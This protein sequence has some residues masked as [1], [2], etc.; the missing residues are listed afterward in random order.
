M[1]RPVPQEVA[2]LGIGEIYTIDAEFRSTD[3]AGYE[4]YGLPAAMAPDHLEPVC[5]SAKRWTTGETFSWWSLTG[6]SCPLPVNESALFIA[7]HAPAEWSYFLAKGWE[8]PANII[9]LYAEY[10]LTINGLHDGKGEQI[11]HGEHKDADGRTKYGLLSAC[12]HYG[13]EAR[14]G[15][16]K[17]SMVTRILQGSPFSVDDQDAI[18]RYNVKDVEDAELLFTRMLSSGD[19]RNIGQALMRG[20]A[21]RGFAVRDR[22]GLPMDVATATRLS[23]HWDSIRSSLAHDVEAT[24]H[25]DVFRFHA[26]GSAQF[27]RNKMIALVERLGM[28]DVWPRTDDH[29]YSFADPQRGGD[30][31]KPFKQMAMLNPYL[32]D[33]RQTRKILE[34]FKHFELPIDKDGRCRGKYAPW[35]QVTGRSSPGKGSIFAMPAWT[36][37]LIEPGEGRGIA[38]VDLKSA[39]FGIGAGLS[40]DPN[41]KQ[42]Y[43]RAERLLGSSWTLMPRNVH[44]RIGTKMRTAGRCGRC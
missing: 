30:E 34:H 43:R 22:N 1:Y 16:E 17:R 38:Y 19:I 2:A 11:G 18:L 42:D 20:D 5:L 40:H 32:E 44:R 41:M 3:P 12:I 21:T 26:D 35:V 24:R 27:D 23:T 29:H 9:D 10:R 4:K 37:W 8:L 14:A 25:Y 28:K 33:L 7:Y 6:E 36:R 31:R 13:L 15:T 39:E